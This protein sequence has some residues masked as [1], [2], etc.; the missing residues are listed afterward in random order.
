MFSAVLSFWMP[1]DGPQGGLKLE[2][3]ADQLRSRYES[4]PTEDLLAL[5]AQGGLTEDA[6][7]LLRVVLRNRG[8][9]DR[10]G[11]VV[12]GATDAEGASSE[13]APPV[14]SRSAV[15]FAVFGVSLLTSVGAACVSYLAPFIWHSPAD[16]LCQQHGYWYA[17][18]VGLTKVQCGTWRRTGDGSVDIALPH[19]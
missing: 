15:W 16:R 18:E 14:A 7:H 3:N 4:L 6:E 1:G 2:I 13:M 19:R 5:L 17:I 11:A 8:A 12:P 9:I 10:D